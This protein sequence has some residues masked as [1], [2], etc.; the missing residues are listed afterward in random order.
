M[1]F[2][3]EVQGGKSY[4]LPTGGKYCPEDIALTAIGGQTEG[5][6]CWAKKDP[7][8][9][10][11]ESIGYANASTSLKITASDDS[12]TIAT[13]SAGGW[14]YNYINTDII[15]TTQKPLRVTYKAKLSGQN[16]FLGFADS[17][18]TKYDAMNESLYLTSAGAVNHQRKGAQIAGYGSWTLNDEFVME[19]Y[20]GYFTVFKNGAQLFKTATDRKSVV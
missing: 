9:L 17:Q 18:A 20:K 7:N 19:I 8:I 11:A 5:M 14:G 13:T 16:M 6:F 3:I 2:N 15:D 1:S 12:Y 10:V 4:L